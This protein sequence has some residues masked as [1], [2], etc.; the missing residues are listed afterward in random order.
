MYGC[1]WAKSFLYPSRVAFLGTYF[2][3]PIQAEFSQSLRQFNCCATFKRFVLL[4]FCDFSGC[5]I[6]FF[7]PDIS[8]HNMHF[9]LPTLSELRL[10]ILPPWHGKIP[11]QGSD[12]SFGGQCTESQWSTGSE[13]CKHDDKHYIMMIVAHDYKIAVLSHNY[14]L[15]VSDSDLNVGEGCLLQSPPDRP[16]HSM[17]SQVLGPRT[18]D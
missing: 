14:Y 1:T 15:K 7:T 2:V 16:S 10:N 4:P 11:A 18:C 13:Y 8:Q 5:G 12:E 17:E 9:L 6:L 3:A